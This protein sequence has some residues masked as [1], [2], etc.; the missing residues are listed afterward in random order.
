M[1]KITT[2]MIV[3]IIILTGFLIYKEKTKLN[4]EFYQNMKNE[5]DKEV[6]RYIY[7]VLPKCEEGNTYNIDHRTLVENA[8]YPKSKLLD[9]NNKTYCS[10]YIKAHCEKEHKWTWSTKLKCQKYEDK[11]FIL[12]AEEYK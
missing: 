10:V 9:E 6:S 1:K 4:P 12:W 2:I 11:G 7:V 8:G 3:I 5:I